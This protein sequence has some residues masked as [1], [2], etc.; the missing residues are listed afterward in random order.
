MTKQTGACQSKPI[1]F[2]NNAAQTTTAALQHA[3]K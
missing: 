1:I 3:L 2:N